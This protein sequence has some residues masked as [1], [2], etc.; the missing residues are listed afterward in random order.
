MTTDIL[1]LTD[2][3]M[4]AVELTKTNAQLVAEQVIKRMEDGEVYATETLAKLTF[5]S[6]ILEQAIKKARELAVDEQHG[7]TRPFTV[8]GVTMQVKETGV[9]YDYSGDDEWQE[10]KRQADAAALMVKQCEERLRSAGVA[11]R[12]AS[13]TM[14]VTLP[15]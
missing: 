5:L 12:S 6:A 1:K 9:K 11:P 3:P 10:L 2:Q 8:G 14:Q 13:T 7:E 15:K 4:A